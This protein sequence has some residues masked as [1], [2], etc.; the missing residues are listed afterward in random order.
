VQFDGFFESLDCLLVGAGEV[1]LITLLPEQVGLT[2]IRR[3]FGLLGCERRCHEDGQERE[4][5]W[6]F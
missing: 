1:Q 6:D 4:L 3:R 2:K 5:G